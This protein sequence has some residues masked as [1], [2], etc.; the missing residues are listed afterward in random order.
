[1]A[2]GW[3]D[4]STIVQQPTD[5]DQF[6]A[7][8]D[9]QPQT[10]VPVWERPLNASSQEALLDEQSR[11]LGLRLKAEHVQER[12]AYQT[13]YQKKHGRPDYGRIVGDDSYSSGE[14]LEAAT[15]DA[16][17]GSGY[18]DPIL[19]AAE[20]MPVA[21]AMFGTVD[22]L[23]R[24]SINERI[25]GDYAS[26]ADYKA[27][28][29]FA[30]RDEAQSKRGLA[31]K[32]FDTASSIPAYGVE[33]AF[34]GGASTAG[35]G[36]ARAGATRVLGKLAGTKGGKAAVAVAGFAGRGAGRTAVMPHQAAELTSRRLAFNDES[37]FEALP[38]GIIDSFIENVS[39]EA[40]RPISSAMAH[41]TGRAKA[42]AFAKGWLKAKPDRTP[43]GL[44]KAFKRAGFD[45]VAIEMI[46]ERLADVARGITG[47]A[48]YGV[49]SNMAAGE[50]D[51]VVEQLVVEFGAFLP[52]GAVHG[53]A[54]RAAGR[55]PAPQTPAEG[56]LPEGTQ[57]LP[58]VP[59]GQP[60]A[61][62]SLETVDAEAF[63][64]QNP[65]EA[66]EVTKKRPSVGVFQEAGLPAGKNRAE[67][68]AFQRR[69]D[70]QLRTTEEVEKPPAVDLTESRGGLTGT[71]VQEAFPGAELSPLQEAEGWRVQLP[72][73]STVDVEVAEKIPMNWSAFKAFYG[74]KYTKS[75]F[76]KLQIVGSY[77]LRLKD[78]RSVTAAGLILL[79][80]GMGTADLDTN[81]AHEA[82]HMARRNGLFTDKEWA[83]LVNKHSESGK[84]DFQQEE[85]IAQSRTAWRKGLSLPTKIRKW[86]NGILKPLGIHRVSAESVQDLMR[87]EEFW[88][89]PTEKQSAGTSRSRGLSEQ[90]MD[91]QLNESLDEL[92]ADANRQAAETARRQAT[93]RAAEAERTEQLTSRSFG[94]AGT[95]RERQRDDTV[96]EQIA[97]PDEE[98]ETA[99][100]K[101]KG[102]KPIGKIA[103]ATEAVVAAKNKGTRA[104]EFLPNN[105][106][107]ATANELLRLLKEVSPA[108]KDQVQ[109]DVAAM[110]DQLGP[111]QTEVLERWLLADNAQASVE[112][113]EPLRF[114]FKS[115]EQVAAYHQQMTDIANQTPVVAQARETR[116]AI[117]TELVKE[118]NDNG[119]LP[120]NILEEEGRIENYYH[121]QVHMYQ[122]A[123]VAANRAGVRA[124]KRA[125][126]K[127]RVTGPEQLG[128]E[129]DFNTSFIE[130]E[131]SWMSDARVELG[132]K[133]ILDQ[134][135]SRYDSM[136][137]IREEAKERKVDWKD[138]LRE[139]P[140]LTAWQP[141]EGTVFYHAQTIPDKLA[142]MLLQD[143]AAMESLEITKDDLRKVLALGA[144]RAPAIIPVEL[145]DQLDAMVKPK[146]DGLVAALGKEL[147]TD[148]K[149]YTLLN[150]KRALAYFI[151][152]MT[153][154]FDPVLG[155][156]A[157]VT[158]EIITSS[159]ELH[160]F[161]SG[162]LLVSENIQTA[163]KMGVIGSG[164]TAQDIPDLKDS[165][166]F[167]RLHDT[168]LS[169]ANFIEKYFEWVK[170]KNEF[171]ESVLRYA[172]FRYYKK[173]L[174]AGTFVH[175][176][177]ARPDVVRALAKELGNDVAAAHLARNLLGDY[178]NLSVM[179]T[180]LRTHAIPFWSWMEIN[181]RRYP[182]MALNA[183]DWA[184]RTGKSPAAKTVFAVAALSQLG[185]FYA[186]QWAWN[187]LMRPDDEDDLTATDR[188]S[189]HITVG[190]NQDGSVNVFRNTGALGDFMEWGGI[191]TLIALYPLYLKNQITAKNVA[192]EM[193]KDPMN[194]LVQG[195]RPDIKGLFEV[196]TGQSLYPDAFSPRSVDRGEALFGIFGLVDEYRALKGLITG[197]GSRARPHYLQRILVGVVDPLQNAMHEMH[198]L[199]SRFLEKKGKRH[200]ASY[201]ASPTRNMRRAASYDDFDAFTDARRTYLEEGKTYES[202]KSALRSLDPIA[203]RLN[204]K[205]EREFEQ[206]FLTDDQ[207]RR[208][209]VARDYARDLEVTMWTWWRRAAEEDTPEQ[210]EALAAATRREFRSKRDQL[211]RRAPTRLT[212]IER[213]DGVTMLDKRR[214]WRE[215]RE[216]AREW[217]KARATAK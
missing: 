57:E 213:A 125:F 19:Y 113:G 2:T 174:E 107:F 38:R 184:Q 185:S 160:A 69:V 31:R 214:K 123:A 39:E 122:Q 139:H 145:A 104:Q 42:L 71:Q 130:A 134:L 194:K 88:G 52:F 154:D 204:D 118:L 132:K 110:L 163:L 196:G 120:D 60:E 62:Q 67:R 157:G 169:T 180:W 44:A 188:A 205:D 162:N 29:Q 5:W 138:V 51:Q 28:G 17:G 77:K 176:G 192:W 84:P 75:Q 156:A 9:Q 85:D 40:G 72:N 195:Y 158:R 159:R 70:A 55:P 151:R 124:K 112:R 100:R 73:G 206:E 137:A 170:E 25:D 45:G 64:Q 198:D 48:D 103:R 217:L 76:D 12:D 94:L 46:E 186:L 201:P 178:G 191:N 207:R 202:Y 11:R 167:E 21:G 86:I 34:T 171:R 209:K 53:I 142:E 66:V 106:Q 10:D 35:R 3:D 152:N 116:T 80:K 119:L 97:V 108:A 117:A 61:T 81:L 135:M 143:N 109:R 144:A 216:S 121:Q 96:A 129:A 22:N 149:V 150:P 105:E 50:W 148:W 101:A 23:R 83:A 26:T 136:S 182:R 126:Q 95:R 114:R 93:E 212:R 43:A 200:A 14:R 79:K 181:G 54:N 63:V 6:S 173:Q 18:Q 111:R 49:F 4:F 155:G 127:K 197:D 89:R 98:V 140:E 36:M 189:P 164:I 59:E 177:A 74:D 190:R 82:V 16:R 56:P 168:T 141:V 166:L 8:V 41:F 172:A 193:A 211:R 131:V 210:R 15:A 37:I 78:G 13:D 7:V 133:K 208:L 102:I 47:N 1:M 24:M 32:I 199:R 30:A 99:I 58:E 215:D 128:E 27:A 187:N 90:Q 92:D 146:P 33:F 115:A 91:A 175:S 65:A 203:S 20:R 68:A 183:V 147:M 153:G 161:Y 87:R 165:R 179:G